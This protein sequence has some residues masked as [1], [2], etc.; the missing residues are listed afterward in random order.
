M[1]KW[2]CDGAGCWKRMIWPQWW[3]KVGMFHFNVWTIIQQHMC[4]CALPRYSF[5]IV[6]MAHNPSATW[7]MIRKKYLFWLM[8]SMNPHKCVFHA[9]CSSSRALM[10]STPMSLLATT[11]S[12]HF[13]LNQDHV[14]YW[15]YCTGLSKGL[16]PQWMLSHKYQ[17]IQLQ[18]PT[19]QTIYQIS[20]RSWLR[21]NTPCTSTR[22]KYN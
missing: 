2:W 13:D 16:S 11:T 21:K 1:I 9:W 15:R 10:M 4:S 14:E 7:W 20:P 5:S 19:K 12:V 17:H 3:E 18:S 6:F 22:R 8:N